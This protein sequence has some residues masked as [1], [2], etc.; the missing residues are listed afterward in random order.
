M[1]VK[2][3]NMPRLQDALLKM[4]HIDTLRWWPLSGRISKRLL[5]QRIVP[6]GF[7]WITMGSQSFAGTVLL[8]T[9]EPTVEERGLEAT[10]WACDQ[11]ELPR[12]E[13]A[14]VRIIQKRPDSVFAHHLMSHVKLRLFTADPEDLYTLKQ[15]SELAQQAID[16]DSMNPV[17]YVALADVFDLMGAAERGLELLSKAESV[18]VRPNWRFYFTRARLSAA[19]SNTDQVLTLL[20]RAIAMPDVELQIV[21]PYVV[22][23]L[24]TELSGDDLVAA[25][26]GWSASHPSALFDL[27][28]A[29]AL[30]ESGKSKSAHAIY[31]GLLKVNGEDREA[32]VNDA[33]LLYKELQQAPLAIKMLNRALSSGKKQ[34]E[35]HVKSIVLTHLGAAQLKAKEWVAAERS[36]VNSLRANPKNIATLDLVTTAYREAKAPEKLVGFLRS[37]NIEAPGLSVLYA[38]LG[39][40][41]SEHLSDHEAAF[42]AYTDA[43]TL[44]PERSDF[45]NGMGLAY[46]RAKKYIQA[47]KLFGTAMRIDPRDAVARYNEACVLALLGR[48]EDALE[49]LA[50]A[51]ILDPRLIETAQNDRDF[52]NLKN[53]AR[54][55]ELTREPLGQVRST[56]LSH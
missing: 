38:L 13:Q 8:G 36:F 6:L 15:A 48:G 46:Y 53:V 50:D 33:V 35:P 12:L 42:Q 44:D 4:S 3:I 7:I 47:L 23:V 1:G 11:K 5:L 10:L 43:I 22:A 21:V 54:F 17:G 29:I 49:S 19:N 25:L 52:I 30:A 20:R 51:L 26:K 27:S 14:V 28:M 56:E 24:Q 31:Q 16:L 37:A 9:A 45:Y 55:Q 32:L 18:G 39:E 2:W 40:T 41:L 34:M